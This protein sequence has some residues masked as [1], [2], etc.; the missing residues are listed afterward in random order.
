VKGD[1]H[2]PIVLA[3]ECLDFGITEENGSEPKGRL[4]AVD[5]GNRVCRLWSTGGDVLILAF[6]HH[7]RPSLQKRLKK[8]PVNRRLV[9]RFRACQEQRRLWR[10]TLGQ[11]QIVDII[12]GNPSVFGE[13]NV[14]FRI[15]L[16]VVDEA[17]KFGVFGQGQ[18]KKL[19]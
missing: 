17:T 1:S 15:R 18:I 5:N 11:E 16:L 6:Q 12:I 13:Q 14:K 2:G 3:G 4:K 7:F 8:M 9:N 19:H 10:Q